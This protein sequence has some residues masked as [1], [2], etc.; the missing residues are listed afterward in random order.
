MSNRQSDDNDTGAQPGDE[1]PPGTQGTAENLC[2]N[3]SGSGRADGGKCEN[4]GGTG[5]VIEG[6]G[7]A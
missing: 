6:V 1:A 2:P 4:C 3:C 7:G 5:R